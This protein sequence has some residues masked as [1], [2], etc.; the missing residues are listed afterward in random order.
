[1]GDAGELA[2]L[3]VT[4]DQTEPDPTRDRS[5]DEHARDARRGRDQRV[6]TEQERDTAEHRQQHDVLRGEA[7][8]VMV[9]RETISMH[10]ELN[11]TR[12][13]S[14]PSGDQRAITSERRPSPS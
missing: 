10:A 4:R 13:A 3:R 8:T 14:R 5:E 7:M 12:Q 9:S 6:V 1:M 2:S 11:C